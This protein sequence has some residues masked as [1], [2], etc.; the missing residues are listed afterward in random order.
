[1]SQASSSLPFQLNHDLLSISTMQ[2][3]ELELK[4]IN[5]VQDI[6]TQT[7]VHGTTRKA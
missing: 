5:S 6:P 2:E 4:E 3:V 7:A 1:M